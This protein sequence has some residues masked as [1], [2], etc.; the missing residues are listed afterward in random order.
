MAELQIGRSYCPIL[1]QGAARISYFFLFC[2]LF[3]STVAPSA[4]LSLTD[5]P[6]FYQKPMIES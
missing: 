1:D 3:I 6:A 5:R 2:G 4:H